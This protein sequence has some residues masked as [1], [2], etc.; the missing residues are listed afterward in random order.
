MSPARAMARDD[1][2]TPFCPSRAIL[3]GP[4]CLPSKATAIVSSKAGLKLIGE[5]EGPAAPDV[6]S[7]SSWTASSRL[8]WCL[9]GRGVL[10]LRTFGVLDRIILSHW[11]RKKHGWTVSSLYNNLKLTSFLIGSLQGTS[12]DLICNKYLIWLQ[13]HFYGVSKVCSANLK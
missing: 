3:K 2:P 12:T 10:P 9:I 8:S 1:F 11:R 6:Q 5:A 13:L 7:Q 4:S